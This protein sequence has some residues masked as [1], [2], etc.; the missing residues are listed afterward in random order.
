[1]NHLLIIMCQSV[2]VEDQVFNVYQY[3]SQEFKT[4]TTVLILIKCC[5]LNNLDRLV[6]SDHPKPACDYVID[7]TAKLPVTL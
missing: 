3:Y 7:H 1:M 6:A 4:V 5:K 2:V